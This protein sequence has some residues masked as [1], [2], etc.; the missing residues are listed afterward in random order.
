MDYKLF[1][2]P[3][4][5]KSQV[6]YGFTFKSADKFKTDFQILKFFRTLYPYPYLFM[7]NQRHTSNISTVIQPQSLITILPNTDGLFY[8]FPQ[9]YHLLVVKTADCLPIVVWDKTGRL[10]IVHAG[11]QGSLN[12]ILSKLLDYFLTHSSPENIFIFIGPSINFCCYPIFG[13]RLEKFRSTFSTWQDQIIVKDQNRLTLDL[14]KL[15]QLQALNLNIPAANIKFYPSCTSC[16]SDVF[17]SYTKDK[18]VK[19]NILTWITLVPFL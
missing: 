11:W 5:S 9:P 2:I 6:S 17:F 1:T 7:M 15:N 4:N 8:P 10:G 16:Q 12:R 19:G 3:I 18:T 13:P 14:K